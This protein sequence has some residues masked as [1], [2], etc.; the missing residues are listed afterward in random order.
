MLTLINNDD[1][2]CASF[3]S[4]F[5]YFS[6]QCVFCFYFKSC[7]FALTCVIQSFNA[8]N[9]KG[10][11]GDPIYTFRGSTMKEKCVNMVQKMVVSRFKMF[12]TLIN[13]KLLSRPQSCAS[14][15]C[16]RQWVCARLLFPTIMYF[17]GSQWLIKR[18]SCLMRSCTHHICYS[19][20]ITSS[21]ASKHLN[22]LVTPWSKVT[23]VKQQ[24]ESESHATL[25]CPGCGGFTRGVKEKREI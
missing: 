8:L 7:I 10:L 2:K 13:I 12:P 14:T 16:V 4:I 15:C 6:L 21:S 17:K 22:I 9:K 1:W 19:D 3:I 24:E 23:G 20:T 11:F 5:V 25:D 18:F